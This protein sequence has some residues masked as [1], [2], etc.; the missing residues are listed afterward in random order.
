MSTL[1]LPSSINVPARAVLEQR[2]GA[3]STTLRAAVRQSVASPDKAPLA[4]VKTLVAGLPTEVRGRLSTNVRAAATT[5]TALSANLDSAALAKAAGIVQKARPVK[6]AVVWKGPRYVRL[7]LY[8]VTCVV[9]TGEIGKDEIAVFGT[10]I[11]MATGET[12]VIPRTYIGKFG[13]GDVVSYAAD[14]GR[15]LSYADLSNAPAL[16]TFAAAILGLVEEDSSAWAAFLAEVYAQL[17][18]IL[19]AALDEAI[20]LDDGLGDLSGAE[21]EAIL[22]DLVL[23]MTDELIEALNEMSGDDFFRNAARTSS[24]IIRVP[25]T[26]SWGGDWKTDVQTLY[27]DLGKARYKVKVFWKRTETV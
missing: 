26:D 12:R 21:V 22:S 6:K 27:Y 23:F 2:L 8:S 25:A 5:S 13:K 3:L 4:S 1:R 17:R 9:K 24:D 7:Y 18:P 20:S 10:T 14:G 19:A 16:P 11:D 15:M